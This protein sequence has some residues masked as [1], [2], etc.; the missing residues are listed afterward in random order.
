[1]GG[2]S[3]LRPPGSSSDLTDTGPKLGV[4]STGGFSSGLGGFLTGGGSAGT[5]GQLTDMPGSLAP[6]G[7][8]QS[9]YSL[10]I[11]TTEH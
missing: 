5:F 8:A 4:S 9:E 1:M 6:G 3:L 2:S 10:T 7:P 11:K